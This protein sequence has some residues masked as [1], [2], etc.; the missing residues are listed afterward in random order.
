MISRVVFNAR[1]LDPSTDIHI[2]CQT[3]SAHVTKYVKYLATFRHSDP[4]A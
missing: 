2:S 1:T 4:A 3:V